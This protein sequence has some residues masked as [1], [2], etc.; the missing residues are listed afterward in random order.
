MKWV[1]PPIQ[2]LDDEDVLE[3]SQQGGWNLTLT[4][5]FNTEVQTYIDRK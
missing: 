1:E 4:R 5:D 3:T 2:D